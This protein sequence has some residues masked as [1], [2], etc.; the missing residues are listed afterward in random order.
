MRCMTDFNLFFSTFV[1]V[2]FNALHPIRTV[3]SSTVMMLLCDLPTNRTVFYG[4]FD[5]LFTE[6]LTDKNQ[7]SKNRPFN[8]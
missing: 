1:L 3:H 5:F 4:A 8:L 7:E 2:M 6:T